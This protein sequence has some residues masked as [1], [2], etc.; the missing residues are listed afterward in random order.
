MKNKH[1]DFIP[2]FSLSESQQVIFTLE[3]NCRPVF[4]GVKVIVYSD[5]SEIMT[6]ILYV[7]I[8]VAAYFCTAQN[9]NYFFNLS[10]YSLLL[11][12]TINLGDGRFS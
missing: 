12:C 10:L 4:F 2:W 8:W 1:I 5:V 6:T 3:K 11:G 9:L 7:F